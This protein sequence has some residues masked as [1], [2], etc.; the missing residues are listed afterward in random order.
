MLCFRLPRNRVHVDDD[1]LFWDGSGN[2][3]Q[4]KHVYESRT[5]ATKCACLP[6]R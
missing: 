3:E 5:H 4:V 6:K 2:D 1:V